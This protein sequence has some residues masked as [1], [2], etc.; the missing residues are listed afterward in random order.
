[1]GRGHVGCERRVEPGGLG[2]GPG[3]AGALTTLLR[4]GSGSV[5][6]AAGQP[7]D[8]GAGATMP[9]TGKT[10]RRRRADSESEED[11]QGSE[12][13]RCVWN[14]LS[15]GQ[16]TRR[17]LGV[18]PPARRLVDNI[19]NREPVVVSPFADKEIE[20]SRAEAAIPEA[21]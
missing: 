8:R 17:W 13:V 6:G 11:E 10:F 19:G 16:K 4:A 1:M 5:L 21:A 18:S 2:A 12:E 3:G 14:G 15:T 7:G 20:G 9:V